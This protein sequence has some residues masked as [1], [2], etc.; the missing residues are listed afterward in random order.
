[1]HKTEGEEDEKMIDIEED[2][3]NISLLRLKIEKLY[4]DYI[5]L[6][7]TVGDKAKGEDNGV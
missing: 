7:V 2:A 1:G 3:P 6:R 5:A 4:S